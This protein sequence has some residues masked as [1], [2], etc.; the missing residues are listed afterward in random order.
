VEGQPSRLAQS[1]T[2]YL[3]AVD[4]LPAG[5]WNR[6]TLCEGWTAANVVAHVLTGDQL[7]RGLV[8]D[9]TGKDRGGQDLP[10]DFPDRQRRFQA[11]STWEPAKLKD[12]AHKESEQT[13]AA[14]A[15]A[16]EQAPDA[17]VTMP[18]GPVPMPVLRGM[19]LNEYII[20][21]HD[22]MPAI[23]RT[24]ASPDWFFDRALGD[25][26]TRMT[27]L[28]PR[29]PHRGKSAS[30]HLHR[31]DG[32]G[33][34]ILRAEGG[35]AVAEPGHARADVAMRG[36]AEGLYWVLMGR[37]KPEEHGVEVHGDPALAAA[38]KEWFPGP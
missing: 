11:M 23:G 10:V 38:F 12:S 15:E 35:Q 6:P 26:A 2:W 20:H 29:S 31:T 13:V 36:T 25:A 1:R 34:W 8:W 18:F 32:D 14:V 4:A 21:G 16:V 7:I 3:E 27:R 5:G 22:L 28:H 19:R 17:I 9:A 30:F 33:E 24:I 37:G